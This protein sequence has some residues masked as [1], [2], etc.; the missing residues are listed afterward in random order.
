MVENVEF[1]H[2]KK[3]QCRH[4]I[5]T[6]VH[7]QGDLYGRSVVKTG[8]MKAIPSHMLATTTKELGIRT[9]TTSSLYTLTQAIS[10][11]VRLSLMDT[12]R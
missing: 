6:Y 4:I 8:G 11:D 1:I 7:L 9:A 5:H 2:M 12:S 3:N 10:T